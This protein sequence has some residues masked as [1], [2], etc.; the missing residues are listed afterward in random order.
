MAFF[1]KI[2][3]ISINASKSSLDAKNG[4]IPLRILKNITPQLHISIASV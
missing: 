1:P 2:C 4:N 3:E